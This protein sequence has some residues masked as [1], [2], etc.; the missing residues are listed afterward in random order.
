MNDRHAHHNASFEGRLG[1]LADDFARRLELGEAP[2]IEDYAREHPELAA[3]IGE[4]FPEGV[5]WAVEK[6]SGMDPSSL[7]EQPIVLLICADYLMLGNQAERAIP[8]I[9][10]AIAA[11]GSTPCFHKVLGLALLQCGRHEEAA[12]AFDKAIPA[13][14]GSPGSTWCVDAWTAAC[15]RDRVTSEQFVDRWADRALCFGQ[16]GPLPWF[17]IGFRLELENRPLEAREA[18]GKA[19]KAGRVS[20]PHVTANWAAYRLSH[21]ETKSR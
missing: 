9:E 21:L 5:T 11:G 12:R 10:R 8:I 6:A 16:L 14:V 15:F 1:E 18:Y 19:V 17:Y 20:N 4:V 7:P 3:V 13:E 2:N